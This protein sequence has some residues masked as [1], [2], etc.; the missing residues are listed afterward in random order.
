MSC[1][2]SSDQKKCFLWKYDG[3]RDDNLRVEP[4]LTIPN[5]F[6]SQFSHDDMR[7]IAMDPFLNVVV[8]DI[9]TGAKYLELKNPNRKYYFEGNYPQSNKRNTLILSNGELYCANSGKLI[10]VFDRL[11]YM[12]SG[13]FSVSENEVIYGQEKIVSFLTKV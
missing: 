8:S 5:L 2:V 10:H 4:C 1:G 9:E 7:I 11:D 6:H 13:I 12:Q 3:L